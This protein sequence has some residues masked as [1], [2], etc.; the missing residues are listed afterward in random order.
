MYRRG[1]KLY[2]R[3]VECVNLVV[4]HDKVAVEVN[5]LAVEGFNLGVER[6]SGAVKHVRV[7]VRREIRVVE[8]IREPVND[9]I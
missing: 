6:V 5:I 7:G 9:V 1:T 2:R 8:A 4:N 3:G